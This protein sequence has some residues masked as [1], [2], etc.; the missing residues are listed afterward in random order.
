MNNNGPPN[1]TGPENKHHILY[2]Q[3]QKKVNIQF[4]LNES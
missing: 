3:T 2:K 1:I 4:V